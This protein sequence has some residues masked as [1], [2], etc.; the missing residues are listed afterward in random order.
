MN[1]IP[2]LIQTRIVY[3]LLYLNSFSLEN[4]SSFLY[5][6]TDIAFVMLDTEY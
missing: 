2:L 3:L 1:I 4:Y 5:C 6:D